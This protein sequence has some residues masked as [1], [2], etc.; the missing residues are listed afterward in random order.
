M[1]P[2]C[3]VV[4]AA[5]AVSNMIQPER[6]DQ[7]LW[8]VRIINEA[9]SFCHIFCFYIIQAER[10]DLR[11]YRWS[12]GWCTVAAESSLIVTEYIPPELIFLVTRKTFCCSI[13]G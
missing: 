13:M 2:F 7:P 3:V 10:L 11:T 8:L 12:I 5:T 9:Y 1:S 6:A 4:I